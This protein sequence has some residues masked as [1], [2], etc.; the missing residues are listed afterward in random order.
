MLRNVLRL[1]LCGVVLCIAAW[2]ARAQDKDR[3]PED[4]RR[5]FKKPE[6]VLES[7]VAMQFELDVGRPDLAALHLRSLLLRK[8]ADKQLLEILDKDGI[9]AVLKLRNVLTWSK[10]KKVQ[11]QAAK[12]VEEL[13]RLATEARKKRL[14]DP[15]RI[16]RF[17]EMLQATP[18]ERDYALRE[19][20]KS[21]TAA[22]PVMVDALVRAT[23]PGERVALRRALA[24]MGPTS[25][26]PLV[27]AL[28]CNRPQT[29]ID[30]LE[31][32]RTQHARAAEQVA[33]FLWFYTADPRAAEAVRRKATEVLAGFLN[34]PPSRLGSAK[35]ALTRQAERYFGHQVTFGDTAAVTVW[36]WDDKAGLVTGWPGAP[37]VSASQAEEYYGLR[38]ARQALA[39][40]PGYR[41]AQAVMLG[42]ALEKATDRGGPVAPLARTSPA[43]AEL[44]AKSNPA[45]VIEL[46]DRALREDRVGV[47]LAAARSLGERQETRAKRPSKAGDPPLVRALYYPDPRLQLAAAEALLNIPGD[48]A[49][50][51]AARIVEILGRFL[52]PAA[53][54]TP[55]RKVL[56]AVGDD[57]WRARVR[58]AVTEAG[59]QPVL[60][61][62]GRDAM[63]QLRAKSEIEAVLLDSTLPMPGLAPLLAQMRADVD[64]A[65][66]PILLAAVPQTRASHDIAQRYQ[67]LLKRRVT[68]DTGSQPYRNLLRKIDRDEA[69]ELKEVAAN[70]GASA[71][72]REESVRGV[73]KKYAGVRKRLAVEDPTG[74]NLV[75][76]TAPIDAEMR[77]LA[78]RYDLESKVREASLARFTSRYKNL[79]V[80]HA[81]LLTDP[82]A[83]EAVLARHVRE[84]GVA[85]APAEQKDAAERAVRLLAA[86]AEGRPAG[87]DVRPAADVLRRTLREGR[88]TVGGQVAAA[89]AIARLPGAPAQADLAAVVM[90]G[91]RPL[92][93][94]VAAT[95]ALVGHIQRF[96]IQ[97]SEAQFAPLR[98]LAGQPGLDAAFRAKLL[99]LMGSLR[100]GD[101]TTGAQLRLYK[102]T[103]AGALPPPK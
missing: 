58:Q 22:L 43:V 36:R 13:I 30:L 47:A 51:T 25:T 12:D 11:T 37:A 99:V 74:V 54:Y 16:K 31:I 92:P 8:P 77:D 85:L 21:G 59:L 3:D 15:V 55:G 76:E 48:P 86:L 87:Y 103:P 45:L 90:D 32:L 100:P 56:V 18:E 28:D 98:T 68:L 97:L 23:D 88:L 50:R 57:G 70:K 62:N 96:G 73:E 6:T 91:G 14:G 33:P 46:L 93:V 64:V 34:L 27:A 24:R 89:E 35:A 10:D 52:S 95:A 53:V 84:A 80:V 79:Q 5:F 101:R 75:K 44:L 61:G 67:T 19:L 82:R 83:L 20:Y 38:F 72:D 81:S 26:A 71:A 4:Y 42:L 66:I 65:K 29:Q 39:L 7:W 41:P 94:R 102:P 17:I 60:V 9:V 63:R 1:A 2:G 78:R 40:D 49:P 69:D